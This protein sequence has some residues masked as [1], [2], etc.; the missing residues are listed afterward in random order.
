ML[1]CYVCWK[2]G[3]EKRKDI[4]LRYRPDGNIT[5]DVDRSIVYDNDTSKDDSIII[6]KTPLGERGPSVD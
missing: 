5:V 1:F 3:S 2:F 4:K 6:D